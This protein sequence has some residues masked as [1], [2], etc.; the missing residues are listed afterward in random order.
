MP[1]WPD[2]FFGLLDGSGLQ[3]KRPDPPKNG[4]EPHS[5]AGGAYD[6]YRPARFSVAKLSQ[7]AILLLMVAFALLQLRYAKKSF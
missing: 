5:Y 4:F 3:P 6:K 7:G 1:T 2:A